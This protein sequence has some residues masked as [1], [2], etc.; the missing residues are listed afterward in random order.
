[1]NDNIELDY[2]P[3]IVTD[4]KYK[5]ICGLYDDDEG[6][7][8]A[9]VYLYGRTDY[10]FINPKNLRSIENVFDGSTHFFENTMGASIKA[11]VASRT[12]L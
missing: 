7:N 10:V 12:K 2:G 5:G 8:K 9:I 11:A 3:V 6:A 4:G 1:M